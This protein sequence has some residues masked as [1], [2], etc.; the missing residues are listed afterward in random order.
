M[1]STFAADLDRERSLAAMW[2]ALRASNFVGR[3]HVEIDAGVVHALLN[4]RYYEL[5]RAQFISQDPVFWEIGLSQDGKNALSNPQLLNSYGYA[6][7]SPITNR[8]TNGK[9]VEI[10]S[11]PI[12]GLVGTYFAHTFIYVTPDNPK[13]IGSIS[14]VD[15]S[16]PFTLSGIPQEGQLFKTAN[17]SAD[18]FY[19]TCGRV[20]PGGSSAVVAPPAG[21]SSAQ[22]DANVVAS[23]N[24]SPSDFGP[25]PYLG[26]GTPRAFG[27]PNSNNAA[28]T[29]L[30]GAGVSQNQIY[31]YKDSM[32]FNGN[33]RFAPGLGVS[34]TSPTYA[35]QVLSTL[36]SVLNSASAVLNS[37]SSS[38][39]NNR[40]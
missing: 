10:V 4:A 23:Y 8:D 5:A 17:Y 13:T 15:T 22:F 36:T 39:N 12:A 9:K 14:G 32:M 31:Q 21:V 37:M 18:Y 2:H 27:T 34:A 28:T 38:N 11:R 7:D 33:G 19:A 24:N 40:K 35:Q 1:S 29:Y 16:R 25:Y 20:C 3:N 30:M 26:W 6:A